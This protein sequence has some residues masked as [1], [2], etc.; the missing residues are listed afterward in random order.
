LLIVEHVLGNRH[1]DPAL[2]EACDHAAAQGGLEVLRLPS[3]AARRGR[4]RVTTDA[5]TELGLA[6]GRGSELHDGDVIYRAPDGSQVV[7]V[8]IP[9]SDALVI[10][11]AEDAPA[12]RLFEMG[13][14]LGHALGN[15]HWP[16][17][18]D[19]GAVI[20]PITLDRKATETV[21]ATYGME[22]LEW[23]VAQVAPDVLPAAAP[24]QSHRHG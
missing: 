10:R 9:P 1:E 4:M 6:L 20:V 18:V 3:D 12:D 8:A 17:R 16:I 21:L 11:P 13:V 7:V 5:G 23:S 15:Q 2:S 22:G 19:A 14:R 24:P